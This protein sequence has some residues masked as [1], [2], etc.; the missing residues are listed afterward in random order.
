MP[1]RGQLYKKIGRGKPTRYR[2]LQKAV[3]KG[4]KTYRQRLGFRG[5]M[6]VEV[7]L[8]PAHSEVYMGKKKYRKR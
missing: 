1:K 3:R 4:G 8:I 7:S 2:F 6:V 5:N